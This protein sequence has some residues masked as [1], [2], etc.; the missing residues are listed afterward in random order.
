MGKLQELVDAAIRR[1]VNIPC[2]QET[3]WKGQ[4]EEIEFTSFKLW[5]TGGNTG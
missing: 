4:K 5:Y 1:L 3:K 2:V